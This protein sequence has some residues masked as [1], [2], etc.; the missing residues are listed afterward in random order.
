M[1]SIYNLL[2]V[3]LLTVCLSA[4]RPVGPSVGLSV[5]LSVCPSL[6]LSIHPSIHPSILL[7]IYVFLSS[8]PP[9]H[10]SSISLLTYCRKEVVDCR[11]HLRCTTA[12]NRQKRWLFVLCQAANSAK[13]QKQYQEAIL[14]FLQHGSIHETKRK[15]DGKSS[16][17]WSSASRRLGVCVCCAAAVSV[18]CCTNL[19]L[20]ML[21]VSG[22]KSSTRDPTFVEHVPSSNGV[23]QGE[24]VQL[25]AAY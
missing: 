16:K 18:R 19:P 12:E 10:P 14:H 15:S 11:T 22:T 24:N 3:F 8:H 2:P 5:C 20:A 7:S 4:G 13:Q 9:I 1:V 21:Q 17:C 25:H 6:N 23:E